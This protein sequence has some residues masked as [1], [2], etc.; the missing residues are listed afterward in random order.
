MSD[1]KLY[2]RGMSV[3]G[4]LKILNDTFKSIDEGEV[5]AHDDIEHALGE[6]RTTHRYQTIIARWKIDLLKNR[7]LELVARRGEGYATLTP[8]ERVIAGGERMGQQMRAM[9]RSHYRISTVPRE[10][11][12][13]I[14]AKNA[15]HLQMVW[16]R[17]L[18]SLNTERK[19]IA[20]PSAHQPGGLP[21]MAQE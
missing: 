18:D 20:P 19:K 7:N 4:D 3:D 21:Q 9:R 11:L 12:S 14:E 10:R 17:T 2:F 15:D 8:S 13:N 6:A 16:A 1:S 5:I